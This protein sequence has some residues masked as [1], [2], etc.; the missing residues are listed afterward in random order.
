[1][2][3][4]DAGTDDDRL[5]AVGV[6]HVDPQIDLE[7]LNFVDAIV[8]M[9]LHRGELVGIGSLIRPARRQAKPLGLGGSGLHPTSR[10]SAPS[11]DVIADVAGYFVPGNDKFISLDIFSDINDSAVFVPAAG[12]VLRFLDGAPAATASFH[13]VLPPD[14]TPG[15]A[16]VGSFT[17]RTSAVGCTVMWK[18]IYAT[19]TRSGQLPPTGGTNTAG[20][21]DPAPSA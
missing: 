16:I 5:D 6:V 7:A 15:G 19:V 1:M 3:G 11:V 4:D 17:W 10:A 2:H 21:T 8:P 9:N 12:G 14:Y 20:M 18:S 13:F